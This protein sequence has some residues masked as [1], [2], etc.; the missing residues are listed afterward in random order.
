[1]FI[2]VICPCLSSLPIPVHISQL[3]RF[4]FMTFSCSSSSQRPVHLQHL[5][6]FIFLTFHWTSYWPISMFSSPL[7]PVYFPHLLMFIFLT[8]PCLSFS[9]IQ[10]IFL[11]YTRSSFFF[12][13]SMGIFLTNHFSSSLNIPGQL[14]HRH[15]VIFLMFLFIFLNHPC[16]LPHLSLSSSLFPTRLLTSEDECKWFW[17]QMIYFP[18]TI[19]TVS[20]WL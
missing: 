12:S 15:L 17:H 8:S 2:L 1:M 4:I 16:H 6:L 5:S 9:S 7:I 11:A 19:N 14:P 13:L 18:G 10:V 3:S 20:T